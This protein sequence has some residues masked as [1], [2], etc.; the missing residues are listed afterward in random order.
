MKWKK[1]FKMTKILAFNFSNDNLLY[2]ESFNASYFFKI[3]LTLL[4]HTLSSFFS[5]FM[6][7]K[8][9]IISKVHY[10]FIFSLKLIHNFK[11]NSH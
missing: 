1:R 10:E 4:R 2:W 11:Y 6:H 3:I 9:A 8:L 7:D 5:F